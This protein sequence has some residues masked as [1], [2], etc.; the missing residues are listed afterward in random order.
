MDPD[1]KKQHADQLNAAKGSD[2]SPAKRV[3]LEE[4]L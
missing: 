1:T 4:D 2:T 3:V